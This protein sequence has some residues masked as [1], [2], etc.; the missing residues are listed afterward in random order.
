MK[1][2]SKKIF[3]IFLV[4]F[5]DLLGFGIVIPLLPKFSQNVLEIHE[6]TIGFVAGIFSLMQFIFNPLWGRLSDIYGR[7]PIILFGLFGNVL[8]YLVLGLVLSGIYKSVLLLFISRAMAGFFSANIGAA[9]AYISDIT[10]EKNRSKGMGIIGAAFGLGFVFGPLIGGIMAENFGFGIPVFLAS[11]LSCC[12]LILGFLILE[13]SLPPELRKKQMIK[14]LR[15][16]IGLNKLKEALNHPNVG[17]LIILYF[18]ITLSIATT[19]VTLPL[20]SQSTNGFNFNEEQIGYL[21][22][23]IGVIGAVVQGI[24]IRPMVKYFEERKILISGNIVMAAGLAIIP[25]SNHNLLIL[26]LSLLFIGVGNGLNQPMTLSMVTR[27]TDRDEQGGILGVNQSLSALARFIG[28]AGSGVIYER[29]GFASPFLIG[30]IIMIFG[31]ILSF[32]LLHEKFST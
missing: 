30:A 19:Y 6:T 2:S 3:V 20:F 31:S 14:E 24:L 25:F 27:Y 7:K 18:L 32:K 23:Y 16:G 28:P 15:L 10:D 1:S 12:A 22:A 11:F 5:I 4:V 17:F 26:L 13:E 9:M 29:I 8:S 21:F